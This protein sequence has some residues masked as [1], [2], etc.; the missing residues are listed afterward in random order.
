MT[1][2]IDITAREILDSRGHPAL[3]A[4]VL[5]ESGGLGRAA[6]PSGA[7]TGKHEAKEL[8][9]GDPKR[10]GGRG[11]LKAAGNLEGEIFEALS[12]MD[13]TRQRH[14]DQ[15]LIN[16]DGTADK[17]RLGANAC[18]AA[19]LACARA[20]ADAEDMPLFRYLGGAPAQTLPVPMMN[21]L[22]GGRHAQNR[23]DFQEFMIMPIGAARFA[24]AVRMGAEI[25][26]ALKAV[27]ESKG[28]NVNL[29]DEGGFAPDLAQTREAL[30]LLMQAIEKSGY[31]AGED[32]VLA[33]DPAASEFY[34]DGKYHIKAEGKS[35]TPEEMAG[36]LAALTADYP[37]F[38]IEDGMAE[39]DWKGWQTLTA[40]LGGKIQ[41]VGDD[42]FVTNVERLAQGIKQNAANAIL[43]KPNQIGTLSETLDAITLAQRNGY[44]A[45]M[46]H[47]SG[48]TEDSSI[49]DLAVAFSCGQIKTG[50]LARSERTAKYNRLLRIEDML[51]TEALYAGA[52]L[53]LGR[54]A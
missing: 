18:L 29:G 12:G 14:I 11:L 1:A 40:G 49:A 43:I 51:E 16:L 9:D 33:L 15:T 47:R 27:L 53:K 32:V 3:E 6:V 19:S 54:G 13:A 2:I 24:E 35:L 44:R 52:M 17:S 28:E 34:A 38:S 39:D 37:I 50:S 21:V 10:Y 25:F 46:S 36:Y 30:D 31:H 45:V 23:L 20:A 8:R 5:L 7:S 22:N 26:Q 48:E 42:I 41:L 4:E